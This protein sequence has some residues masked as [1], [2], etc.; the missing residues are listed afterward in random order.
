MPSAAAS[1]SQHKRCRLRCR[2]SSAAPATS[3]GDL[4][5]CSGGGLETTPG[6]A[7]RTRSPL[8]SLQRQPAVWQRAPPARCTPLCLDTG[9]CW[10]CCISLSMLLAKGI[11][12][13]LTPYCGRPSPPA[14]PLVVGCLA[15]CAGTRR[16]SSARRWPR[17]RTCARCACW[18]WST[19]C[20]CRSATRRWASRPRTSRSP[21]SAGST[22]CRWRRRRASP[23]LHT[24]RRGPTSC[25][26]GCSG[27]S[28]TTRYVGN[29]RSRAQV[30]CMGPHGAPA[31]LHR[32]SSWH[33]R[34]GAVLRLLTKCCHA[35]TARPMHAP[36]MLLGMTL[37]APAR[38][39]T[40]THT[41]PSMPL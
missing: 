23:T 21:T 41:P 29:A 35:Q 10:V 14:A 4:T 36:T 28:L 40:P 8:H 15:V 5:P 32:S 17:P 9:W 20:R 22:S 6:T 30:Q 7:A 25:C 18:T 31:L 38:P 37:H 33:A 24:A 16:R 34:H 19:A 39:R 3:P 12:M 2:L 27:H 11:H 26:K 1:G 13:Y